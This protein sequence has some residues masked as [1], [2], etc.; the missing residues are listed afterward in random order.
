ML[1]LSVLRPYQSAPVVFTSQSTASLLRI[2]T[3]SHSLSSVRNVLSLVMLTP[4][5]SFQSQK[6]LAHLWGTLS[7]PGSP[8]CFPQSHPFLPFFPTCVGLFVR[9][10][11]FVL[12]F[13][14]EHLECS[15]VLCMQGCYWKGF[16]DED[17]GK[18][19]SKAEHA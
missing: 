16:P 19:N 6:R 13:E 12:C 1:S 15:I 3:S 17:Q 4:S 18:P 8:T 11:S 2:F 7:V 9:S 10:A 14:G 5:S